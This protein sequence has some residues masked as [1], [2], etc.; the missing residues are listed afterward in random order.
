MPKEPDTKPVGDDVPRVDGA[1]AC[2]EDLDFQRRWWRF[3]K[4]IWIFFV[5]I[6][7]ADLAGL[8]GRGPLAN[9]KKRNSSMQMKYERVMRENT[10]SILTA[11]PE[12]NA[13]HNGQLQLYVSDSIVKQLG[14]QRI[15]PQPLTSTLGHG[16]ITYTFPATQTPLTV[17]FELKPSFIGT[18]TFTIAIPGDQPLQAETLVLP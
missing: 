16:G 7:I 13:I 17:Q 2:G 5:L 14:A 10:A 1:N 18:H 9:A 8:L 3:E 11:L 12:N 4:A 15:I 6:L